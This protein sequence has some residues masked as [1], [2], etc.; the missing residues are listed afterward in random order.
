[1]LWPP[2]GVEN[3]GPRLFLDFGELFGARPAEGASAAAA[4]RAAGKGS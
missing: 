1:M 2:G 4:G 3:P